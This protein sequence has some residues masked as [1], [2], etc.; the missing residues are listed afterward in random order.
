M[1]LYQLKTFAQVAEE[2]NLTRAAER[3][4]TSQPAISAQIKALEEELGV[5]LFRRS[6][7]GMDLTEAGRQLHAHALRTLASAEALKQQ[8]RALQDQLLGEPRIGVHTDFEFVRVGALYRGVT[9]AHPQVRP[10]FVQGMSLQIV[11]DVRK[12]RLD[13][14]FF[15]GPWQSADLSV[16]HL[17]DT[18]MRVVG[19]A[20][21]SDR[22]RG[23]TLEQL[24]Q[25]PWIYTTDTCPFH[26][27][28]RE[29]FGACGDDPMRIA[30]VDSEDAVRELI[31]SGAGLSLL[32]ADD[33]EDAEQSGFGCCWPGETPSIAL[34]FTVQKRRLAEPM[35]KALLLQVQR[36]WGLDSDE[37]AS[38]IAR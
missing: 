28:G 31:R 11:D 15:F 25:M 35:V 17:A 24:A 18:P 22:I 3:L 33:A 6:A 21:W 12:G 13:A 1:E 20:G 14:G 27:V 2:G 9:G 7:R 32:R 30:Y 4:F 34:Q 5:E 36:L 29:L 37:Q 8:A 16:I 26:A 38:G 19:P 23:A 10:H